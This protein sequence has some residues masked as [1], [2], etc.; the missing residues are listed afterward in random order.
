VKSSDNFGVKYFG[1][2][3]IIYEL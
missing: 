2:A 3:H 1:F